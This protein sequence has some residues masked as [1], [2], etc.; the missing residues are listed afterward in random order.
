M[1][2]GSLQST[3]WPSPW[4][5]AAAPAG[6]ATAT[7]PSA[8][9]GQF[10]ETFSTRTSSEAPSSQDTTGTGAGSTNLLQKLASDIQALLIQAQSAATGSAQAGNAANPQTA[11][12]DPTAPASQTEHHHHHHHHDGGGEAN[13]ATDVAATTG[14]PGSPTSTPLSADQTIS[15]IFVFDIT[16]AI[17][18]YG[19]S[20]SANA[21]AALTA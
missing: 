8:E 11:N 14:G 2:I 15:S 13:G 21:S 19:G 17:Q 16:Q 7:A 12:A 20:L 1:S 10:A 3:S 6:S 18:S 4:T 5:A 9:V